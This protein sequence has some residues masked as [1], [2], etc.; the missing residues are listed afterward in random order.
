MAAFHPVH[1]GLIEKDSVKTINL[2]SN[3]TREELNDCEELKKFMIEN[4]V[5]NFQ[6]GLV[7][8]VG[9]WDD[10]IIQKDIVDL[11]E[12]LLHSCFGMSQADID[13]IKF[14][15]H[16]Y[17]KKHFFENNNVNMNTVR[18]GKSRR[19]HRKTKRSRK[20]RKHRKSRR[21]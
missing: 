7:S 16:H 14:P 15:R 12:Q 9:N 11:A 1:P 20:Y 18:G 3:L 10:Q 13:R 6:H 2:L 21:H 4:G 8:I 17:A 19:K 5:I